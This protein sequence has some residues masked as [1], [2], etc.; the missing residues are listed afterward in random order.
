MPLAHTCPSCGQC[1]T[2][3]P[4]PRDP[5]YQL[6]IV[7]CPGCRGA[8]VR[9]A[10]GHRAVPR[11]IA[12]VRLAIFTAVANT[13]WTLI[14]AAVCAA[15]N[16]GMGS[17]LRGSG[18]KIWPFLAMLVGLAPRDDAFTGWIDDSG[19]M[20]LLT[21]AGVN[22]L[23]GA[24]L[25]AAL[26][27]LRRR[28]FVPLFAAMVIVGPF[29]PDAVD[30][31]V[32]VAEGQVGFFDAGSLAIRFRDAL[33]GLGM[34]PA[35]AIV[36]LAGIPLGRRLSRSAASTRA[37]ARRRLRNRVRRRRQGT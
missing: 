21:W 4:A 24:F 2:L 14:A 6:P 18:L 10:D 16:V 8:C 19:T 22:V 7:V 12:R 33:S 20:S 35:G 34:F 32:Q 1:L 29:V 23:I 30:L 28:V 31:L 17:D 15:V 3:I 36:A 27:H 9:Y 13:L 26:P 11:A 25:T 5:I 37:R